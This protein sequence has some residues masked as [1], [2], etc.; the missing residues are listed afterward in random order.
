MRIL[1]G[2]SGGSGIIQALFNIN[3]GA[4]TLN[5]TGYYFYNTLTN[6]I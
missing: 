5:G 1:Y 6:G 4:F 2:N 3:G